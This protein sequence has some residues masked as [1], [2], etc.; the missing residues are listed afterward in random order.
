VSETCDIIVG[1][2]ARPNFMGTE[3]DLF[4]ILGWLP[5]NVASAAAAV[6]VNECECTEIDSKPFCHRIIVHTHTHTLPLTKGISVD[7]KAHGISFN[8]LN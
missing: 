7:R 2:V 4:A 8:Y 5:M 6:C 3:H 1:H